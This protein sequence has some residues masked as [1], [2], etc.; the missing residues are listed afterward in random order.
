MKMPYFLSY[1]WNTVNHFR[2]LLLWIY[3]ICHLAGFMILLIE[4]VGWFV[5]L[6]LKCS[7]L[8]IF[9]LKCWVNSQSPLSSAA[10]VVIHSK[11]TAK[12]VANHTHGSESETSQQNW[13]SCESLPFWTE[14]GRRCFS[15]RFIRRRRAYASPP[16]PLSAY[17][18]IVTVHVIISRDSSIL[19]IT[20]RTSSILSTLC[21]HVNEC[22]AHP[23]IWLQI[24]WCF[25]NI[26]MNLLHPLQSPQKIL[27]S[28]MMD[29]GCS[30]MLLHRGHTICQADLIFAFGEKA[31]TLHARIH[32]V[33]VHRSWCSM[34]LR[35]A[36]LFCQRLL[37]RHRYHHTLHMR[38]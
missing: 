35:Y 32:V 25:S 11:V 6:W 13:A 23:Q 8:W 15:S 14:S 34:F 17:A 1:Q 36:P 24:S 20:P 29:S 2:E 38:E 37:W 26:S 4:K 7:C 10:L 22:I 18:P 30:H 31:H 27:H 3:A 19:S 5:L 12:K 21:I 28:H 33:R 16:Q 9:Y